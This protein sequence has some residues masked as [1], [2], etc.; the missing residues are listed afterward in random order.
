MTTA[1]PSFDRLRTALNG[2]APDRVPLIEVLVDHEIKEAF[3]GQ[4]IRDVQADMQFWLNA[5][6]DVSVPRTPS[7][8]GGPGGR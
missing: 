4:P 1:D 2:R 7:S 5:R 6:Y 3:L 8:A